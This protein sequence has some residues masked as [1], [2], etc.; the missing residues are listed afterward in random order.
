[1]CNKLL[2]TITLARAE[3]SAIHRIAVRLFVYFSRLIGLSIIA[4]SSRPNFSFVPEQN[5]GWRTKC[6]V[7]AKSDVCANAISRVCAR[8]PNVTAAFTCTVAFNVGVNIFVGA[9]P[10]RIAETFKNRRTD[11]FS[12]C[13]ITALLYGAGDAEMEI[14]YTASLCSE[15]ERELM[16]RYLIEK[17]FAITE[18]RIRRKR[19]DVCLARSIN[20]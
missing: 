20:K 3:G 16:K 8:L 2:F 12:Q 1:M 13:R 18:N 9:P 14:A 4:Q 7:F 19:H 5:A 6:N 17:E 15:R 11:F 10:G